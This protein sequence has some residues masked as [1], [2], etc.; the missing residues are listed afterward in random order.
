MNRE[1]TTY[2]DLLDSKG[3][4]NFEGWARHP[5]FIYD[6]KK[7]HANKFR[8]KEW[9]Y[10][11]ILNQKE[12][13]AICSTF[14]DLGYAAMFAIS[15]VDLNTGKASQ[16]DTI[17]LLSRHKTGLAPSSTENH[18][19]T[20]SDDKMTMSFIKKGSKRYLIYTAP[21]LILPNGEIGLKVDVTLDQ[22]SRMES[23]N[24]ATSWKENRKAF[25]LNEKVV[26]MVVESGTIRLGNQKIDAKET[27]FLGILDWGRGR[28][29]Y[30]NKWYWASGCY[31]D[32]DG[33]NIGLNLGYGF[34]DRT[35]ASENSLFVNGTLHKLDLV[36]FD[37]GD[38]VMKPWIMKDN[39]GRLDL[40]FTPTA[41]RCSKTKIGPILSDQQQVFGYYKG[42]VK[43]DDGEIIEID[44]MIGFA[45]VVENKY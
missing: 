40:V 36:T 34:T 41:P 38:D 4:L 17:K 6:R 8:I 39:E 45:E 21:S 30:H 33:N 23:I 29:T 43:T 18:G 11:S 31:N 5:L 2:T 9:D 26:G 35:P 13:Y 12:G 19:I 16:I 15:Y 22:P 27:E 44:N 10:Y 14:S 25:Y 24:I 20:F 1:L 37:Y 32:K 7:I 28:W 3:L 42:F